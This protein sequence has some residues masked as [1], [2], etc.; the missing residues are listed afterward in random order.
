[1]KINPRPKLFLDFIK[2]VTK[3]I[4]T[5]LARLMEGRWPRPR[6]FA[7]AALAIA[8]VVVMT[9]TPL[10]K[11]THSKVYDESLMKPVFEK[12]TP[13]ARLT[14]F[15]ESFW[16]LQSEHKTGFSWGRGSKYPSDQSTAMLGVGP[17]FAM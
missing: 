15:D 9:T 12:W 10:L 13:T 17:P 3:S 5:P 11:V 8:L 6:F 1:M 7:G 4:A 2:S 14:I 16:L